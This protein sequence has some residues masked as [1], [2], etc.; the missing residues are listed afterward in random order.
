MDRLVSI[1][2]VF[3][4]PLG[5]FSSSVCLAE[6][7]PVTFRTIIFTGEPAPGTSDAFSTFDEVVNNDAGD[8]AFLATTT[9]PLPGLWKK[10]MDGAVELLALQDQPVPGLPGATFN[11]FN[12]I[13][14]NEN[15]TVAFIASMFGLGGQ[16]N[17][18]IFVED[19]QGGL[20]IAAREGDQAPLTGEPGPRF[21]TR[22]RLTPVSGH[23]GFLLNDND[24]I[25]FHSS[26][27]SEQGLANGTGVFREADGVLETAVISVFPGTSPAPIKVVS[28]NP[29][30]NDAG[31]VATVV[32]G[33][34]PT[35]V[36]PG[37]SS[38]DAI[39]PGTGGALFQSF[40]GPVIN[41]AGEITFAATL[42][43]PA[44]NNSLVDSSNSSA[45]YTTAGQSLTLVARA[46]SGAPGTSFPFASLS[47]APVFMNE[48]G[49]VAFQGG[50]VGAPNDGDVGIWAMNRGGDLRKV[51]AEGDPAPS[52][53]G[54]ELALGGAVTAIHNLVINAN[55][56][57]AFLGVM[58]STSGGP[59]DIGLFVELGGRLE[60]VTKT[61]DTFELAPGDFRSIT[62]TSGLGIQFF[63]GGGNAD[64][65]R[66][67]FNNMDQAVVRL[68]FS[69]SPGGEAVILLED[70]LLNFA[71]SASNPK[72]Q[73][74]PGDLPQVRFQVIPGVCY[75]V[76]TSTDLTQQGGG[77][78]NVGTIESAIVVREVSF[79]LP[80]LAD[81][82]R[83]FVRLEL[84]RAPT[85]P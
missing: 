3:L 84:S 46:G 13:N 32:T 38:E 20:R 62:N 52:A 44:G 77:Y 63:G 70:F 28:E 61:G 82:F 9:G 80:S 54:F 58:R 19:G 60:L 50:L 72:Y 1:L 57:I 59:Q 66:S 36:L 15:G 18:A 8:V 34:D 25:A 78:G 55:G 67:G 4:F 48:R 7:V 56:S 85:E 39:A 74:L 83:G 41:S 27:V 45:I 22:P 12:E 53:P 21:F 24:E 10:P 51:F 49:D 69:G 64:G 6:R 16:E 42:K 37:G 23:R 14:L 43:N 26:T 29:T 30:F 76:Q 17:E 79:P 33:D 68:E 2:T 5:I 65:R 47:S 73:F 31:A 40:R 75:T 35:R 11:Q 81:A 71:A